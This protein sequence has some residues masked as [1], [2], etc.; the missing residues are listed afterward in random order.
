MSEFGHEKLASTG[1]RLDDKTQAI[2]TQY[3]IKQNFREELAL[4]LEVSLA[5]L[6]L[7]QI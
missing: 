4:I 7:L 1:R 5:V 6:F 3:Y 2:T